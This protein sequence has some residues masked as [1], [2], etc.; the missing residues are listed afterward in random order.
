M[1]HTSSC[2]A[3]MSHLDVVPVVDLAKDSP[4]RV[5]RCLRWVFA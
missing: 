2:H 1:S 5:R 3:A 4:Q